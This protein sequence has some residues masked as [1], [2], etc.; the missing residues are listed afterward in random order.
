MK[1]LVKQTWG[2][3]LLIL[4]THDVAKLTLIQS[5]QK[6]TCIVIWIGDLEGFLL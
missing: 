5:L 2:I 3:K 6:L 1:T 4:A